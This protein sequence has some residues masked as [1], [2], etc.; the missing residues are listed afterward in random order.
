MEL[1]SIAIK[2]INEIIKNSSE[3]NAIGTILKNSKYNASVFLKMLEN[4][5]DKVLDK[6]AKIHDD[7]HIVEFFEKLKIFDEERYKLFHKRIPFESVKNINEFSKDYYKQCEIYNIIIDQLLSEMETRKQLSISKNR[8]SFKTI[9][10]KYNGLL[11]ASLNG[12][13]LCKSETYMGIIKKLNSIFTKEKLLLCSFNH[14]LQK[15]LNENENIDINDDML[16]IDSENYKI[17]NNCDYPLS[18][19]NMSLFQFEEEELNNCFKN[20]IVLLGNNDFSKKSMAW[21]TKKTI[22]KYKDNPEYEIEVLIN[23]KILE[24]L[25]GKVMEYTL[26]IFD[27]DIVKFDN[28]LIVKLGNNISIGIDD[29]NCFVSNSFYWQYHEFI[30]REFMRIVIP[31]LICKIEIT[32]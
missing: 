11:Y 25:E 26:T 24:I 2:D 30:I 15:E 7:L 20:E 19:H 31:K 13:I 5:R 23:E 16:I 3:E 28:G 29:K 9:I 4:R 17:K 1:T 14:F 27:M 18:L 6:L 21:V 32:M 22:E 12:K 8:K 10:N